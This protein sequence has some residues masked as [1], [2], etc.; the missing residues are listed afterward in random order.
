MSAGSINSNSSFAQTSSSW[1]KLMRCFPCGG[2]SSNVEPLARTS[3][4]RV[5]NKTRDI[6]REALDAW[7]KYGF[8][9]EEGESLAKKI[10]SSFESKG[11]RLYIGGKLSSLPDEFCKLVHVEKL[12]IAFT[13][14]DKF[15]L[16][17]TWLINLKYLTIC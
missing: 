14:F 6:D 13:K 4:S 15:P 10:V 9:G 3:A 5:G 17:I 2:S 11:K 1:D 16:E 7:V 8:H 12:N